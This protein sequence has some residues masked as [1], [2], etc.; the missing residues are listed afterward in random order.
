MKLHHLRIY[1]YRPRGKRADDSTFIV[2]FNNAFKT[3]TPSHYHIQ[4]QESSFNPTFNF[5]K[6][7]SS[8][9]QGYKSPRPQ[10]Q[11]QQQSGY[12]TAFTSPSPPEVNVHDVTLVV[13]E[14]V[15]QPYKTLS[16]PVIYETPEVNQQ[17]PLEA[18]IAPATFEPTPKPPQQPPKREIQEHAYVE[19]QPPV[20][21]ESSL[22]TVEAETEAPE[23]AEAL[24]YEDTKHQPEQ[25]H[26]EQYNY[27][28][29]VSPHE[30]PSSHPTS[31]D[32]HYVASP[33]NSNPNGI[34]LPTAEG[35]PPVGIH[36]ISIKK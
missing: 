1:R 31:P 12:Q 35:K 2:P 15:G 34:F 6:E 4:S 10:R 25:Q 18:T 11:P 3:Q 19:P 14:E 21:V 8:I 7:F 5:D 9:R 29:Y 23:V 24:Y 32:P 33:S 22:Y 26:A 36:L 16:E 17:H 13:E 20:V 28:P 30:A 27:P